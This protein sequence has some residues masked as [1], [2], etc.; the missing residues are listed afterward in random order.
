M[1]LFKSSDIESK[2]IKGCQNRKIK[3]QKALYE[4]YA[5]K[6]LAV[7][8]R[9][10][11]NIPDAED[12]L[13]EGFI[14][15]F[16]KIGQYRNEGSFEGWLRR[17]FVNHSLQFLRKKTHMYSLSN[18][19]L[20]EDEDSLQNRFESEKGLSLK[21]ILDYID[22]LPEGYKLIFNM[23][24]L[25]GYTHQEIANSLNISIGT[26]K[27]QLARAK[28]KLRILLQNEVQTSIL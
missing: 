1:K 20:P 4:K 12:L 24:V 5:G 23:Y 11:G 17:I 22:Q 7:C 16:D 28:K 2:I 14:V 13:Q 21:E 3:A 15:V 6:M 19:N 26:S 27:S 25:D 18:M 10:T 9:Y 8:R